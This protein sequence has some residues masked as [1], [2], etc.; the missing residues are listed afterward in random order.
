MEFIDGFCC[1]LA[2]VFRVAGDAGDAA[3]HGSF[4]DGGGDGRS[5]AFIEGVGNDMVFGQFV[6]TDQRGD[7]I[8]R[9]QFHVFVDAAGPD[10]Q[11]AAENAREDHDVVD[12]VRCIR[13][14]GA[15]DFGTGCLSGSIVCFRN[16]VGHGEDDGI[17][18]HGLDDFLSKDMRSRYAEEEVGAFD[19]IGQG[20]MGMGRIGQGGQ[21]SLD[22]I[23]AFHAIIENPRTVDHS[24]VPG[25]G[26]DQEAADGGT[27]CTGAVDDDAGRLQVLMDIAESTDDAGQGGNGRTVLVVMEDGDVHFLLQGLFNFIA[28]RRSNVF[29]VD[30]GKRRL[31]AFHR[32]D[33][34][35]R[36]FR[37]QADR[38]S[39]DT[40]KDLEQDR[41]PFHDRHGRF[42][43]DVAQAE[44]TG[45]IGYDSNHVAA[46]GQVKRQV[47]IF[48]DFPARLG[49]A[50]RIKD[51]Q[52]VVGLE[53]F[54]G[55]CFNNAVFAAADFHGFFIKIHNAKTPPVTDYALKMA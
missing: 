43:P 18:S 49:N 11:G 51:T 15:D 55:D 2:D 28:L 14:A 32:F 1:F 10:G 22:R 8:G 16:G 20:P 44:D 7:G 48:R 31:Q 9:S 17:G 5:D 53:D 45:P 12:L 38:D 27:G 39:I 47:R 26:A 6:I 21:F 3:V 52:V 30:A 36:V 19:G 37:I 24:D 54:P 40:A 50:R 34:F 25:T 46:A 35:L 13:P 4:G 23:E 33:K 29:Q 42:R 41:F